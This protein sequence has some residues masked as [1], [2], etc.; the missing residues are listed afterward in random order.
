MSNH[1]SAAKLKHPGD[2]ARLDLTDLFVFAAPGNPGRTVLIMNSNPF[3]KGDGFHPDAVYRFNIDTDG[4]TLADVAFSFTFSPYDNGR[5]TA[6]AREPTA[7]QLLLTLAHWTDRAAARIWLVTATGCEMSVRC[8]PP[9]TSMMWEWARWAMASSDS[10]VMI[11]S[12][13][14]ITYQD[15]IVK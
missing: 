2:D 11:W 4:D 13:V 10:G 12:F 14:P 6:T 15:G 8:E 1:F 3:T 7:P 5:Q 9:G